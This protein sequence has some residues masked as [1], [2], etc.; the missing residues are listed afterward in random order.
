M[1]TLGTHDGRINEL[2]HRIKAQEQQISAIN[3][4][5]LN[6][7]ELAVTMKAM[8]DEQKSQTERITKLEKAPLARYEKIIFSVLSAI[9]GFLSAYAITLI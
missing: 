7:R 3:G 8:L 1:V 9:L 6:V 2:Y 4:I 5:S